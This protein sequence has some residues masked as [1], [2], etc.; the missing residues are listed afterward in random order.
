MD[1]VKDSLKD[2][3]ERV[4]WWLIGVVARQARAVAPR[5]LGSLD[6]QEQEDAPNNDDD[7]DDDV[8]SGCEIC[9]G[10]DPHDS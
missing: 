7:D 9:D 10:G 3:L 2:F 4:A 6:L 5:V 8:C 1:S